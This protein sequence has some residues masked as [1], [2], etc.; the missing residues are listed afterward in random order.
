MKS[1]ILCAVA[2]AC[3]TLVLSAEDWPQFRGPGGRAVSE[4]ANPPI[5]FGQSSNVVWKVAI[6]PGYSS[7]VVTGQ[8]IVLTALNNGW[9][10]TI[11]LNRKDG[12]ILWRKVAPVDK[13]KI[14]S[15]SDDAGPATPTPVTDGKSV[16]IHFGAFGVIAYDLDGNERWRQPLTTP[17]LQARASPILVG[18]WLIVLLD[19]ESGSFIEARDKQTGQIQ[20]H[21]ERL[22]FRRNSATPFLW[23]H[24]HE[25]ELIV[26]GTAWLT[27]YDAHTGTEKWV[28]PESL[29]PNGCKR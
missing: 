25:D 18:D 20:W 8:R 27:S 17:D 21:I 24:D 16:Y 12:Q 1:P 2:S 28:L 5:S 6:P 4:S 29:C 13:T 3:I 23:E 15:D 7:P 14:T 11:C 26:P 9:L 10:E 22:Q 19:R